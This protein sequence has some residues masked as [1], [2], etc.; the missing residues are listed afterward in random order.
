MS[1]LKPLTKGEKISLSLKGKQNGLKHGHAKKG[2]PYTRT[3]KTWASMHNRCNSPNA[4]KAYIYFDR[5][6]KVCDRWK[7]FENFLADMGERPEGKTLD[8]WPDI[9]GDYEPGNCRWATP[10][11]QARNTRRNVLDLESA[12]KVAVMRLQ[13]IKCKDIAK[14]FGIS[15]TLPIEIAKGRCWPDAL[16]AAKAIIAAQTK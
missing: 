7:S 11:E 9:N 5:G 8:R 16:A 15:P 14:Q 12:T 2:N 13:G 10:F 4:Q 1:E 3:Y 6:I